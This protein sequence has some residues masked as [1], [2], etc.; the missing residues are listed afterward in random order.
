MDDNKKNETEFTE[1]KI[2]DV[3]KAKEYL[4]EIFEEKKEEIDINYYLKIYNTSLL[5]SENEKNSNVYIIGISS[6]L[7]DIDNTKYF[8]NNKE[9][10]NLFIFFDKNVDIDEEIEDNIINVINEIME[11]NLSNFSKRPK[12]NEGKI[13]E[14]AIRLEKLNIMNVIKIFS[15]R[16]KNNMKLYEK[17]NNDEKKNNKEKKKEKLSC[18]DI[19]NDMLKESKYINTDKGKE[20]AS[21]KFEFIIDFLTQFYIDIDDEINIKLMNKKKENLIKEKVKI[22]T[23]KVKQPLLDI[24]EKERENEEIREN[25][26]NG[27]NDEFERENFERKNK[28]ERALIEMKLRKMKKQID[29]DISNYED[30]LREKEE[31]NNN[32]EL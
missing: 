15:D 18:I 16:G 26:K 10:E 30:K 29:D 19:L 7:F 22:Y 28:R 17:S 12:S 21:N 14:D 5:L 32:K 27:L 13:I 4:K 3:K 24:I 11:F 23:K 20:I 25:I 8:P 1:N 2:E 9:N 6:L 31:L